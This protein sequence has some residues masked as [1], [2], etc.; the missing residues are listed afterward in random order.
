VR[1]HFAFYKLLRINYLKRKF[2]NKPNYFKLK[3]IVYTHF[4]QRKKTFDELF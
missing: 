2:L 3:S 1:A 4:I